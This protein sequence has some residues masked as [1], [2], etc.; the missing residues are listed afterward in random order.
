MLCLLV[1]AL[2]LGA[3]GPGPDQSA[4][5]GITRPNIV[6]ILLDD[7]G[8]NDLGANGN[9]SIKTPHLDKLASE[10]VRFTR[11]YTDST[12]TA[13][14]IGAITGTSPARHGFRPDNLGISPELITLPEVLRDVGYSTH[15][16]GKWHMGFASRLAWP[17]AQGF[18]TFFGFLNQ[19]LMRNPVQNGMW[20]FNR[21]TFH[22]PWLQEN[23]QLPRPY[24][25]HL[26]AILADRAV[27][28]IEQRSPGDKPWF[29]NFWT[30]APHSPIQPMAEFAAKYP[31]TPSG[32][33]RA[34]LE[35][36]DYSVGRILTKLEEKG[37][38][39]S[40]V[41]IVASDN[42]GTNKQIDNNAPYF[43]TKGSFYEG[44]VRTPMIM[45][46]P[47]KVPGGHVH[48]GVVSNLDYLPTLATAAGA[49]IPLGLQGSDLVG[50]VH[51]P[52]QARPAM[53]WE[54][55]NSQ[56]HSW[57]ALSTDGRWRMTQDII[58]PPKLY[59]L[60]ARPAGDR[61]VAM[62]HPDILAQ[63]HADFLTWRQQQRQ[64]DLSYEQLDNRGLG[65]VSG[66]SFERVPGYAGHTFAIGLTPDEHQTENE[67]VIALQ[68]GQW[69]LRQIGDT[70]YVTV[71]GLNLEAPAPPKG[72]CST[73]IV[74][75][76]FGDLVL[77]RKSK[78]A[79]V[80]VF[81]NAERVAQLESS[82]FGFPPDDFLKPTYLGADVSG[83][84]KY[85]G[86]LGKPLMLNERLVT[87]SPASAKIASGVDT[88]QAGLCRR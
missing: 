11:H 44:G 1:A 49:T 19:F 65:L 78:L 55:G 60:N 6:L 18:D 81:I 40:T 31:D 61:D 10:G 54:S 70:L 47:G 73:V 5:T 51:N 12:C 83:K 7:L 71:Q 34:V 85:Q 17:N 67:Q 72:Q 20:A 77:Y 39:D 80:E 53:Y 13:T 30:Y 41:V 26:S 22:N 58:G 33:Y 21:P 45:R 86:Q 16:I 75:S 88:I 25:G 57:S 46:W 87:P 63:L 24:K 4:S 23:E 8:F 59:D 68:P 15:H 14:R 84:R 66:E 56:Y 9:P 74:A 32:H 28:F 42:G 52:Q 38:A 62:H 79:V 37:L 50:L 82:D 76:H 3:C 69:Q 27:D 43:G 29:L 2:L 48:K 36:V 35:Q 64:V